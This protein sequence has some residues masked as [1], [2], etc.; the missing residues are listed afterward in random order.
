MPGSHAYPMALGISES[1][2][3]NVQSVYSFQGNDSEM[4][5][6]GGSKPL[7]FIEGGQQQQHNHFSGQ[8]VT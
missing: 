5:K 2:T 7:V 1:L 3:W 8:I 6:N 4:L